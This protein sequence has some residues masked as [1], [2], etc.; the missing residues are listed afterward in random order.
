MDGNKLY[1][2]VRDALEEK[3]DLLKWVIEG[4]SDG[5]AFSVI[6]SRRDQVDWEM[7][8]SMAM[9]KRLMDGNELFLADKIEELRP[10]SS[11]N[12]K[13]Y[14]DKLRAIVAKKEGKE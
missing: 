14:V 6:Q 5:M 12:W 2:I 10:R 13:W 8:A 11:L 9:N 7:I 1:L 3:P 4:M